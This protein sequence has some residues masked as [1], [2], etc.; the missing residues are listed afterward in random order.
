MKPKWNKRHIKIM[1]D[2]EKKLK[3]GKEI[4]IGFDDLTLFT[5][6]LRDCPLKIKSVRQDEYGNYHVTFTRFKRSKK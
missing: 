5:H 6:H 4:F 3:A 2:Y 1:E